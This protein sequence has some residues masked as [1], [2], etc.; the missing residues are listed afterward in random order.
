MALKD[1]LTPYKEKG[2]AFTGVFCKEHPTRRHGVA[3]DRLLALRYTIGGKT[4]T[5]SFGW[6]SDGY[7]A[8][9][10]QEKIKQFRTNYKA[11][12]GP[13]S[14]AE[15]QEMKERER[16]AAAEA[17][18]LQA[19]RNKTFGELADSY[20]ASVTVRPATLQ[21]YKQ[22]LGFA[23][24]YKPAKG[25]AVFKDTPIGEVS[26][27]RL[28]ELVE[29]KAKTSPSSA[30]LLRSALSAFYT[31]LA[32][33]PRE[34]VEANPVPA[35]PRPK[36]NAPRERT[37]TD[38]ELAI[39]WPALDSCLNQEMA[40]LVKFL[41]LTGARLSE[42][43]DMTAEEVVDD[44]WTVPASRAKGK[45][46][47]R[48]YLANAAKV[49]IEGRAKPFYGPAMK[50]KGHEEKMALPMD[51]SSVSHFLARNDYFR[52]P[53]FTVHDARRTLGSGLALLKFPMETIAAVLS[54]KLPGVTAAHYLRHDMDAE[55]KRALLAWE[56][57]LLAVVTK[58]PAKVIPIHG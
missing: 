24:E 36:A 46:P 48:I 5:E 50:R 2:K 3:K 54:H 20:L 27:K 52:L 12:Q 10:A 22:C 47:H 23:K 30:V 25:L 6:V 32:E 58:Q 39:L 49:L 11:G 7:T 33:P 13:T 44:W 43:L 41:F 51:R 45:R 37:L 9:A 17:A 34:Y 21:Q 15:E 57:H 1:G 40:R 18:S 56:R 35:I 4:R 53:K 26:R 31:W 42:A 29:A 8:Q 55:K 16:L 14:L 19:E 38:K 28:A